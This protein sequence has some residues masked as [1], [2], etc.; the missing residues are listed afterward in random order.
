MS[1]ARSFSTSAPRSI[2]MTS[3]SV[4]E[5]II[6]LSFWAALPPDW[7]AVTLTFMLS[8]IHLDDSS[9]PHVGIVYQS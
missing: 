1:A 8:L 3:G 7:I 4:P 9:A 6:V 5:A 2:Q